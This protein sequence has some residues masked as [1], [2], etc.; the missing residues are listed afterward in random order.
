[1]S[2]PRAAASNTAATAPEPRAVLR[3]M[4]PAAG[5]APLGPTAAARARA[6]GAAATAPAPP[7]AS[8][9]WAPEPAKPGLDYVPT[10]GLQIR[11]FRAAGP[12][13]AASPARSPRLLVG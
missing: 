11:A 8:Q 1:M 3:P 2:E 13:R 12:M 10:R 6:V 9:P 4:R 5:P 7:P